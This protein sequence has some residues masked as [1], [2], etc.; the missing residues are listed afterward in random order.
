MVGHGHG[1]AVGH[2][3]C[4]FVFAR[5]AAVN[6]HD[7]IGI[8]LLETFV[9]GLR[10]TVALLEAQ[11]DEGRG[12]AAERP[13]T[14]R[15]HRSGRDAVEVEVA[16]YHHVLACAKGLLERI[17]HFCDAGD[18]VGVE[19]I[20]LERRM[21]KRLGVLHRFDA[22]RDERRRDEARQREIMLKPNDRRLVSRVNVELRWHGEHYLTSRAK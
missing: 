20:A 1:D 14:A 18:I 13:Q 5:D 17:G 12:E 21:E 11:R 4:H 16:E 2:D 19:P 10:E 3:G 15:E 6:R 7:E 8:E 9:G 22:A